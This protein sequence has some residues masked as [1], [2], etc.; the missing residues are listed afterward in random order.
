M[1][2]NLVMPANLPAASRLSLWQTTTSMWHRH[3]IVFTRFLTGA[4]Q[5]DVYRIDA[6]ELPRT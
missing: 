5:G 2:G 3:A 4:S 6:G 1:A